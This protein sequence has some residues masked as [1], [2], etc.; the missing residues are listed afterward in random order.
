MIFA[1]RHRQRVAAAALSF[2]VAALVSACGSGGGQ[3]AGGTVSCTGSNLH[4]DQGGSSVCCP[5]DRPYFCGS[6]SDLSDYG[7]YA[8]EGEASAVCG[9]VVFDGQTMSLAVQCQ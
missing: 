4:C 7:C 8:T 1:M 3:G 9:S 2:L 5:P 6:P